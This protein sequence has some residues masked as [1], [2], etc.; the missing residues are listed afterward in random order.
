[1]GVRYLEVVA[2]NRGGNDSR[3]LLIEV[4]PTARITPHRRAFTRP[5]ST[6]AS[7]GCRITVSPARTPERTS[8]A[9][10]FSCPISPFVRRAR[11][12]PIRKVIQSPPWRNSAPVGTC[13]IL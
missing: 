9:A 6:N 3:H 10:P 11:P 8:A 4:A 13:R 5:F 7:G 2:E 12:D 1:A